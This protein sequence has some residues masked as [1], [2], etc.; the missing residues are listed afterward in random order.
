MKVP[1]R[2]N[3]RG[4]PPWPPVGTFCGLLCAFCD[5]IVLRSPWRDLDSIETPPL[6]VHTLNAARVFWFENAPGEIEGQQ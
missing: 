1:D 4:G 6:A 2:Y 3:C 5:P